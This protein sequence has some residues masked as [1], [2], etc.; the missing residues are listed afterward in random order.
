[1]AS[2]C[3]W[4]PAKTSGAALF[5]GYFGRNRFT[6]NVRRSNEALPHLYFLSGDGVIVW[7]KRLFLGCLRSLLWGLDGIAVNSPH[8]LATL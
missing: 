1:M 2:H 7:Q 3:R 5:P 8:V 6:Q 4:M